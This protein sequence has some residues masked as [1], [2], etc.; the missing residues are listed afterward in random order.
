[1]WFHWF[2]KSFK[3][4]IPL[5]ALT[6]V[7]NSQWRYTWWSCCRACQRDSLRDDTA[8]TGVAVGDN[9]AVLQQRLE[10]WAVKRQSDSPWDPDTDHKDAAVHNVSCRRR[11]SWAALKLVGN[12]NYYFGARSW[13]AEYQAGLVQPGCDVRCALQLSNLGDGRAEAVGVIILAKWD[14]GSRPIGVLNERH[15]DP[16]SADLVAANNV[17]DEGQDPWPA[18][19]VKSPWSVNDKYEVEI[20]RATLCKPQNALYCLIRTLISGNIRM[21]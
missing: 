18:S 1:M 8:Q 16:S 21:K 9:H 17:W 2:E 6:P 12:G 5:E 3:I 15:P 20:C 14:R 13:S 4:H 7:L 10:C 19:A 11:D